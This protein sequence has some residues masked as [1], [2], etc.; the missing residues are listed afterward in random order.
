[1]INFGKNEHV[2]FEVR[3]H[4]F[5]IA[6][7]IFILFILALL[8]FFIL[9]ILHSFNIQID[10]NINLAGFWPIFI[11]FYSFWLIILWII[12]FVFW[13]NYFLDVWVV[14]NEKILD[15]EQLGLFNREISILH[16]DKIQDITFEV[17]GVVNTFLKIG[18]LH[19]QTAGQEKEFVIRG[20]G[21]PDKVSEDL[22]RVLAKYWNNKG[23]I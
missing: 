14:T 9:E 18:D 22:N 15:I 8:P 2:L 19:I 7:E 13:T 11:F 21:S 12:G 17:R 6:T 3:K 23:K 1:M 4:W 10:F 20:I 16:L 5:L